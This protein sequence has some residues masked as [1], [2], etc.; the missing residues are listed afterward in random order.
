MFPTWVEYAKKKVQ[1]DKL[2]EIQKKEDERIEKKRLRDEKIA[3]KKQEFET[4]Q[5]AFYE[6]TDDVG[7]EIHQVLNLAQTQGLSVIGPLKGFHQ[8]NSPSEYFVTKIVYRRNSNGGYGVVSTRIHEKLDIEW[9]VSIPEVKRNELKIVLDLK[10]SKGQVPDIQ[11][12]VTRLENNCEKARFLCSPSSLEETIKK[13]IYDV[14][15][16]M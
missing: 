6:I 13:W 3:T 1:E 5:N 2:A 10:V 12:T 15:K 8:T 16:N 11:V 7:R 9:Y 14:Y 4:K